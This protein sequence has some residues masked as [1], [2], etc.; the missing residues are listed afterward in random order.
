M[1]DLEFEPVDSGN[2]SQLSR[3]MTVEIHQ[4]SLMTKKYPSVLFSRAVLIALAIVPGLA[5]AQ[6]LPTMPPAGYDKNNKNPAGKVAD[7][8]YRS[9]VTNSDRTMRVYTPPG[10]NTS[11]KYPVIY[12]IHGISAWPDTIFADWCVGAAWVSDN[13]L[14]QKK[15]QPVIIVAMDNNDVDSHK[16][17]IDNVIPFVEKTY[18]VVADADHRGLYGYSMGGGVTF[19]EGLGNNMDV[20]HHVSPSSATPFNHPSDKDMFKDLTTFKQK[21]KTL[22]ISCGTADWDGFYPPNETTHKYAESNGFPHY[23]LAVE[24]GGHDG[25]VWRPAMWNFLQLAFPANGGT[26]GTGGSSGAG[27]AAGST[28]TGGATGTAGNSGTGPR[29]GTT[30]GTSVSAGGSS[31]LGGATSSISS[32]APGG[33]TSSAGNTSSGGGRTSSS[34][35][36]TGG[37]GPGGET[38]GSASGGRTSSSSSM[39]ASSSSSGGSSSAASSSGGSSSSSSSYT[40][41]GVG[42][43][44]SGS[45]STTSGDSSGCSCTMGGASRGGL[46]SSLIL[47]VFVFLSLRRRRRP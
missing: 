6:T 28:G 38:A 40:S 13:L 27:G 15:I 23:W 4:R 47:S 31:A 11:E 44:T 22:F 20:F 5:L 45:H 14:A 17:L 29:G 39:T 12:G 36:K 10:Y 32:A 42:G 3:T 16:E 30:A 18:P 34:S 1:K 37:A 2:G 9:S 24:G 7:V 33:S 19:A 35:G 26:G 43:S 46:C 21:M 41:S 25:S 8:K